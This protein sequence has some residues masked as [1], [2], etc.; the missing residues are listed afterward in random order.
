[1]AEQSCFGVQSA[2]CMSVP[3]EL[4]GSAKPGLFWKTKGERKEQKEVQKVPPVKGGNM[5]QGLSPD[6]A[7]LTRDPVSETNESLMKAWQQL[8]KLKLLPSFSWRGT[9]VLFCLLGFLLG[10]LQAVCPWAIAPG[11]LGVLLHTP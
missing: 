11:V 6:S 3:T 2:L 9:V 4:R 5:G 10:C 8:F 1:M 7:L